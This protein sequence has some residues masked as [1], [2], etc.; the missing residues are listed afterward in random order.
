MP[1]AKLPILFKFG[2]KNVPLIVIK[3]ICII[4]NRPA[5]IINL[6]SSLAKPFFFLEYWLRFNRELFSSPASPFSF[7]FSSCLW[8]MQHFGQIVALSQY[9]LSMWLYQTFFINDRTYFKVTTDPINDTFSHVII[10]FASRSCSRIVSFKKIKSP[11]NIWHLRL[12]IRWSGLKQSH[13]LLHYNIRDCHFNELFNICS[14]F[15]Q[16]AYYSPTMTIKLLS[17]REVYD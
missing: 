5:V 17:H 8:L 15:S 1:L 4:K 14:S 12:L 10:I 11:L 13:L 2:S 9:V 3:I 7:V 6:L 16:S